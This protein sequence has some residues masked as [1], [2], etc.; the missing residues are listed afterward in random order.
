MRL[1]QL[2][3][4]SSYLDEYGFDLPNFIETLVMANDELDIR[5]MTLFANGNIMQLLEG[6]YPVVT[7]VFEKLRYDAK[8][9]G[10]FELFRKP[11]QTHCL[12]ETCIGYSSH[13]LTHISKL[14][15]NISVFKLNPA[16]VKKRLSPSP[17][18]VLMMQFASDYGSI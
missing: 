17:V 3:Y 18:K 16:E 5:G 11:L 15:H 6:D 7:D 13:E 4:V 9:I 14:P 8:Q 2:L 12:S 10:I 1:T